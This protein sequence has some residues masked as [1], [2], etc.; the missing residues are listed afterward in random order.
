[1]ALLSWD[2]LKI[3]QQSLIFPYHNHPK[4]ALCTDFPVSVQ[5]A[6]VRTGSE[7]QHSDFSASVKLGARFPL[8]FFYDSYLY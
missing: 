7:T 6:T 5:G 2:I 1:M 4:S 8:T 3:H